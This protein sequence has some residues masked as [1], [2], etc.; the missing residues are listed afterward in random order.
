MTIEDEILEFRK[1]YYEQIDYSYWQDRILT[2]NRRYSTLK[3]G[4]SKA[5]HIMDIYAIYIQL[6]EILLIHINSLRVPPQHFL[7]T[8]AVNNQEIREFGEKLLEPGSSNYLRGFVENFVY[9]IRGGSSTEKDLSFDV[10]LIKECITEYLKNYQF[11]N[12][13]KHGY[14]VQ[15]THGANYLSIRSGDGPAFKLFEGNSQLTYYEVV[16][17]KGALKTLSEISISFKNER[18]FGRALFLVTLLENIRISELYALGVLKGKQKYP[19]FYI[20]DRKEWNSHF[21]STQFKRIL[22]EY[23]P[24]SNENS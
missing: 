15:S 2:A 24:A 16:R 22:F 17:K 8:L 10:N 5:R 21:G 19:V 12:S 23:S 14:R 1:K 7:H 4:K 11:L 13:Y 20:K 18:I 9:K 3:T 6:T